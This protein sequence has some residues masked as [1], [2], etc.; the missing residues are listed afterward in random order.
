MAERWDETWHR[1]LV[2]TSGQAPS[3]RLAAQIL[4]GDGFSRLDPSHPLGGPDGK[5]DAI[6]QRD[7]RKWIMAVYFPRGQQA[8]KA[9]RSKFVSDAAGVSANS[10]DGI[11]FVTNQ[12]LSLAERKELCSRTQ[13]A[14]EIY[15]LE[16]IVTILDQPA[17]ATVR[18]QYLGIDTTPNT[19][20][21]SLRTV[22]VHPILPSSGMGTRFVGRADELRAVEDFLTSSL[23]VEGFSHV[24][25]VAGMPGVGKTAFA[26]EV[27]ANLCTKGLFSG[28]AFIADFKGYE[29]NPREWVEPSAVLPGLLLA[30][31]ADHVAPDAAA[32]FIAYR[33]LLKTREREGRP[34][35]LLL[36]NVADIRQAHDLLPPPGIHRVII[37]SRNSLS[38]RIPL[39]RDVPLSILPLRQSTQLIAKGNESRFSGQTEALELLANLCGGLPIALQLVSQILAN[40]PDLS[41]LDIAHELKE[42]ATR[43]AGLEFEDAEIRAVFQGSYLRLPR[44]AA[45][46]LRYLSIHPGRELSL[47]A[48]AHLLG[49][50]EVKARQALRRLESSHL[51]TRSFEPTL[52][53]LHDLLRLYGRELADS[54]DARHAQQEAL[55]R[56]FKYYFE[57]IE[58][59]N[60]WING[61]SDLEGTES[62]EDSKNALRWAARE[63][64]NVV[65]CISSASDIGG[66][67]RSWEL[68]IAINPYLCLR[69][70]WSTAI[71][72]S[73]SAVAAAKSLGDKKREGSAL[74][75]LGLAYNSCRRHDDGKPLFL[76]ARKLHREIGDKE[77]EARVLSG[78]SESMRAEGNVLAT[79]PVLQRAVRLYTEIQD[80]YGLGFALTNLATSLRETKQYMAAVG[81]LGKALEIHQATGARRAEASTLG[82]L[83]AALGQVGQAEKAAV[84]FDDS[85]RI[86]EGIGDHLI[87]GMSYMNKGNLYRLQ[88]DL[89]NTEDLYRK[90]LASFEKIESVWEQAYVLFNMAQ[91][92]QERGDENKWQECMA[93]IASLGTTGRQLLE[94][95]AKR[96]RESGM[97]SF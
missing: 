69:G 66:L 60:G 39:S 44:E 54:T 26:L 7:G 52:W 40:D 42:E 88:G 30:L 70:D 15:H 19:A 92:Y 85:I 10:A 64:A 6:M 46:C 20:I 67:T 81:I 22:F 91:W 79:I 9:I 90:S 18:A 24:G 1:L 51:I 4:L 12:E 47:Q 32:N 93:K 28:G 77:G 17:M 37:T 97:L 89:H 11:A 78:L 8:F 58:Q 3:E 86:A 38:P 41:A 87:A 35:L 59:V 82:Q 27:A 50:T 14:C 95:A 76:R 5:K 73:E 68:G 43:L 57:T 25:V 16:R 56:L 96:G 29:E 13:S 63:H 49:V 83:G 72:V 55:H 34:I 2:W 94:R 65:A 80:A 48:A 74:N 61:T 33:H 62:F 71:K 45:K 23:S 75:N 36:D 21:S 53:K 31:G 84:A